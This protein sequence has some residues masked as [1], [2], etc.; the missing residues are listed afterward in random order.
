MDIKSKWLNSGFRRFGGRLLIYLS[1]ID[2]Y[3]STSSNLTVNEPSHIDITD[4]KIALYT[5]YPALHNDES[6]KLLFEALDKNGYE[7]LVIANSEKITEGKIWMARKNRGYDLAA[8]R[9]AIQYLHGNPKYILL[10]NSSVA[11]LPGTSEFIVQC[12]HELQGCK[13][14]LLSLTQS[15][16]RHEHAQSFFFLGNS[17]GYLELKKAYGG[18]KNWR[19]KRATVNFGEIQLSKNLQKASVSITYFFPYSRVLQEHLENNSTEIN[20]I[21]TRKFLNPTH[22][23]AND[24]LRLGAPFIK[25]NLGRVN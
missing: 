4:K 13:T 3:T 5:T 1:L 22:H 9:D 14:N 20:L 21:S 17:I 11:W 16:Q 7:L 8:I 18:M 25:R 24:L 6:E 23:F 10:V 19:T 2:H 12:E 15:F